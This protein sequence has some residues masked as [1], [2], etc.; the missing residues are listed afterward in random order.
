VPAPGLH[1]PD[2]PERPLT[3]GHAGAARAPYDDPRRSLPGAPGRWAARGVRPS[4]HRRPRLA[5]TERAGEIQRLIRESIRTGQFDLPALT[6]ALDAHPR[7][8]GTGLARA[9][10]QRYLPG[11]EDRRSWLETQFQTHERRDPRLPTP[12][13]NQRLL[14]YEIDVLWQRPRVTLELDGRPYHIAV[15]DF[16]HDRAKDRTLQRHGWRPLRASDLEW[17][18]DRPHVLEDLYA[19][20]GV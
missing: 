20:L 6:A 18:H 7:R 11:S 3:G 12:L 13:Y 16:D 8:P 17:E 2:D 5:S 15:E 19:V 10:L 9:A 4:D 14:G 1:R